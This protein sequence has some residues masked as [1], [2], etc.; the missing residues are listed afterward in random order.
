MHPVTHAII[1][2]FMQLAQ[3]DLIQALISLLFVNEIITSRHYKY[4]R[5]HKNQTVFV[6][7]LFELKCAFNISYHSSTLLAS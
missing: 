5:T 1:V 2:S 3:P 7:I 4:K 6:Y